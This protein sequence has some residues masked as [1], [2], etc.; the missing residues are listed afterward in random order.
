MHKSSPNN[1][2]MEA[3]QSYHQSL[4]GSPAAL[5]LEERGLPAELVKA[6][7]LGYVDQPLEGHE[8]F[9]D[10]LV[11]PYFRVTATKQWRVVGIKFRPLNPP[12]GGSKYL[13][14][15]GFET[16]LFNTV[17]MIRSEKVI[18]ICEGEL[19]TVAASSHGI[20]AV[21]VPGVTN[22]KPH[23]EALFEGYEKVYILGDG[24]TAGRDFNRFLA[25]KLPNGKIISLP[26]NHD[27]NSIIQ[28]RG[29]DWL[30]EQMT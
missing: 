23:Y 10:S 17:D 6:F 18:S 11:I 16:K 24:D 30:K 14:T 27:V 2:L 3:A 19:D 1:S 5:L 21:G 9:K 8:R 28:E 26:D 4:S 20:P 12:V 25:D 15:P 7:R 22:W 29:A 13:N